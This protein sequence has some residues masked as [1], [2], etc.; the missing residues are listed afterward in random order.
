MA[1]GDPQLRQK[2]ALGV[3]RAWHW[4]QSTC[5]VSFAVVSMLL[6]AG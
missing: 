3:L 5:P 1:K 2:L 6:G 4:A